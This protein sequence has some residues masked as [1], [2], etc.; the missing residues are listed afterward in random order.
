MAERT[1]GLVLS[2]AGENLARLFR[3]LAKWNTEC[4][5]RRQEAPFNGATPLKNYGASSRRL[6]QPCWMI[7]EH[8]RQLELA[9]KMGR[10]RFDAEGLGRVVASV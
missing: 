7:N 2:G 6:L 9:G 3:I 10:Q 8:P 1:K 4:S 5:S